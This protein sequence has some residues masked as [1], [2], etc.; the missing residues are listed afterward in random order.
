MLQ[1]R[2]LLAYTALF[3]SLTTALVLGFTGARTN[4]AEAAS[5]EPN[6][7][8][9]APL[10]NGSLAAAGDLARFQHVA[11][12][13]WYHDLIPQL[14]A[15]NPRIKVVA[16]KDMSS[17]RSYGCRNGQDE[18]LLPAGVGY[19]F[20]NARHPDWFVLDDQSRRCEW[21]GYPGHWQM[22]VGNPDYQRQW[23][24]N[25]LP[26]L[27]R[28]GWDGVAIDNANVSLTEGY[29]PNRRFPRYPSHAAYRAATRSFLAYVG[30]RLMAEGFLVIP[31][32]QAH[33]SLAGIDV[34]RDWL[35]FTSG[36][37]R[38]YWMRWANPGSHYGGQGW[39]ELQQIFEEV[40]R[41]GKLFTTGTP[42]D[43]PNDV[44]SMRWGRA[45]FLIGWNGGPGG[46]NAGNWHPEWTIEIGTPTGPRYQV[47]SAW[48]R[49]Y[50]GGTA[51]ANISASA[52]QTVALGSTYLQPDGLRVNSVTLAPLTG[53]VLRSTTRVPSGT[54]TSAGAAGPRKAAARPKHAN[55]H[56]SLRTHQ[57]AGVARKLLRSNRGRARAAFYPQ[58]ARFWKWLR[59]YIGAEEFKAHPRQMHVRPRV[60]RII[61]DRWW[62]GLRRFLFARRQS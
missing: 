62:A 38:E 53:I 19:C 20:A 49:D 40:Q 26:E 42:T 5:A 61:P 27:R 59:W 43:G 12:N 34:W 17:T 9:I 31:N 47:G 56:R 39:L 32:I 54:S 22:D 33:G 44:R 46:F 55:R 41:R 21:S 2:L 18:A 10:S 48:R 23:L 8:A 60:T 57:R 24:E 50:T 29:C 7:L 51:I 11:L 4:L 35:Q 14:K 52:S 6:T 58:N 37:T 25:V 16:Y 15:R 28:N 36:G 1:P 3:G 30:P 13:P 45:S